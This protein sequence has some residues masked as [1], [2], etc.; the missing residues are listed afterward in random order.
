VKVLS[1][2]GILSWSRRAAP[3]ADRLHASSTNYRLSR[4][5]AG[6]WYEKRARKPRL[7]ARNS[8][9]LSPVKAL[10]RTVV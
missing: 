3:P 8:Y 10:R 1:W 6:L 2:W 5:C 9:Q 4:R 7:G